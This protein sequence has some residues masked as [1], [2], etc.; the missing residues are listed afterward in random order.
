MKGTH[1]LLVF[2]STDSSM[3]FCSRS[4]MWPLATVNT[5]MTSS[6]LCTTGASLLLAGAVKFAIFKHAMLRKEG[7]FQQQTQVK[8]AAREQQGNC[9]VTV[10][11][12]HC[13][14]Q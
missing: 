2:L 9:A 1:R 11:M 3:I 10:A 13:S 12:R 8:A 6:F 14:E 7:K 4:Y 5:L